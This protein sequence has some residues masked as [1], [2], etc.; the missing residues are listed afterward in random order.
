MTHIGRNMLV[1]RKMPSAPVAIGP[2]LIVRSAKGDTVCAERVDHDYILRKTGDIVELA[3][4]HVYVPTTGSL[5]IS[6]S[7]I[8]DIIIG[9]QWVVGH[10]LT[11]RWASVYENKP[12]IITFYAKNGNK[13]ICTTD[14]FAEVIR[15]RET[16]IR[17][18]IREI[19]TICIWS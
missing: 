1:R 8:N 7:I 16:Y 11:A 9:K 6:P 19:I 2:W 14:G 4:E 15:G 18:F 10:P 3:R 17:V 5:S 13:V 12:E